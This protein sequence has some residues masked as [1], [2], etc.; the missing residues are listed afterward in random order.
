MYLAN[1]QN[2]FALTHNPPESSV[3][4]QTN[5]YWRIIISLLLRVNW[6]DKKRCRSHNV[7]TDLSNS[8]TT[9]TLV[10]QQLRKK[11]NWKGL[12]MPRLVLTDKHKWPQKARMQTENQP[13]KPCV[14]ISRNESPNSPDKTTNSVRT[15]EIS[16]HSSLAHR[17][18]PHKSPKSRV[19]VGDCASKQER[20]ESRGIIYSCFAPYLLSLYAAIF[21]TTLIQ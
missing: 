1:A 21:N 19:E 3:V 10:G 20:P 6:Q 7:N 15:A 11:N 16:S 13:Y 4:G 12:H 9:Q 5:Y 8:S 2:S 17:C 18:R 14:Q